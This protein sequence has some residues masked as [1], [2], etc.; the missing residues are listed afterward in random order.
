MNPSKVQHCKE[1]SELVVSERTVSNIGKQALCRNP[2]Y[3]D[4]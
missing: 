3:M 1:T 4:F 2:H